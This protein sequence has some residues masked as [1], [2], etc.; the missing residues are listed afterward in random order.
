MVFGGGGDTVHVGYA[1]SSAQKC[2]AQTPRLQ[3]MAYKWQLRCF[4]YSLIDIHGHGLLAARH[5]GF[6]ARYGQGLDTAF[7]PCARGPPPTRQCN[8]TMSCFS[9]PCSLREESF[10]LVPGEG[11]IVHQETEGRTA[12][13]TD[14]MP[15]WTF[16]LVRYMLPQIRSPHSYFGFS[17]PPPRQVFLTHGS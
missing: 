10:I 2:Q 15:H 11:V 3:Q 4:C 14:R 1:Q 12:T 8:T 6:P 13:H 16:S 5:H 17:T 7:V 9:S